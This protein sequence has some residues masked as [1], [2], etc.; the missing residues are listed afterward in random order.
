MANSVYDHFIIWPSSVT[1]TF[2]LLPKQILQIALLYNNESNCA[3][4][5][6]NLCLNVEVMA[7][8]IYDHFNILPSNV[9]L[10]INLPKE[11]FQMVLLLFKENNC[12]KLF[13]NPC[14]NVYRSHGKL[15]LWSFYHLTFQCD[16]D[17]QSSKTN[18]STGTTTPQEHLCKTILK[19]HA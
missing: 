12:A 11:V 1:L 16:L 4:L 6:R 14:L 19:I 2:N 7:S 8:S 17:L 5:F 18:V 15:S 9:T 10:T 13:W 3:R